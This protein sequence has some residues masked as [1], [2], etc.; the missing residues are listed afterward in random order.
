[1]VK[2]RSLP[3]EEATWEKIDIVPAEKIDALKARNTVDPLKLE[4][5]FLNDMV[6]LLEESFGKRTGWW[7][8]GGRSQRRRRL[9]TAIPSGNINSRELIGYCIVI[10]TGMMFSSKRNVVCPL[11]Y[12]R[13]L[14]VTGWKWHYAQ[15]LSI[16][17]LYGWLVWLNWLRME[18]VIGKKIRVAF[19]L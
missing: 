3:Y 18:T 8:D 5:R 10:T 1:M 16:D 6:R 9:K 14:H 12:Q 2:W 19:N 11:H 15:V 17:I 7:G 13:L 4:W